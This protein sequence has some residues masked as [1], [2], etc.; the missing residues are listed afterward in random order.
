MKQGKKPSTVVVVLGV[1]AGALV[2]FICVGVIG[3]LLVGGD[4]EPAAAPSPTAASTQAYLD[5]LKRIDPALADRKSA[6]DDGENICLD[7][8]QGK[9]ATTLAK[10][11]ASRYDTDHKTGEA[12][13]KAARDHLCQ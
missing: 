13:V 4:D 7:I 11:A 9:E 10:N 5:A 2:L 1:I 12:I 3:A 8:E 6:V